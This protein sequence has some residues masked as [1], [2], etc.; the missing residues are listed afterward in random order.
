MSEATR[1]LGEAIGKPGL[2]YVQFPDDEVR[3]AMAGIG[4]SRSVIEAMLEMQRGFSTGKIRPTRERNAESTTPTTL[5]EFANA[6]FARVYR[7]AA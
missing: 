1:F 5:E 4:M 3:L 6:V 2:K 7:A